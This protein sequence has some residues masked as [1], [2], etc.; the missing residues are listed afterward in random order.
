METNMLTAVIIMGSFL[1]HLWNQRAT[2]FY[3]ILAVTQNE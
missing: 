3:N 2:K 1:P